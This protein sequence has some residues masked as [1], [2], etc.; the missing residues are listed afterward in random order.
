MKLTKSKLKEMVRE[1][2]QKLKE[3][4]YF[5][6]SKSGPKMWKEIDRAM[7]RIRDEKAANDFIDQYLK[8][9]VGAPEDAAL[10]VLSGTLMS[11]DDDGALGLDISKWN[12]IYKKHGVRL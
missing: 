1:E 5:S 3:V 2:I 8:L 11:A 7:Q 6:G 9:N 10:E 12:R 4:K